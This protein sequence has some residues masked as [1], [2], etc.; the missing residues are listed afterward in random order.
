[1]DQPKDMLDIEI[2][3]IWQLMMKQTKWRKM[4]IAANKI[5][6]KLNLID[7]KK[8]RSKRQKKC[9]SSKGTKNL[10][11]YRTKYGI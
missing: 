7:R 3:E 1:M 4:V 9:S 6:P 8:K 10:D 5:N 11:I 2:E